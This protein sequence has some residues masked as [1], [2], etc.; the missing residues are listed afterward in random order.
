MISKYQYQML[1]WSSVPPQN[2][3][4]EHKSLCALLLTD[5]QGIHVYVIQSD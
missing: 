5:Q 3:S 1:Q 2:L 4:V